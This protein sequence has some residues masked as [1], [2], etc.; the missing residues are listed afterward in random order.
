MASALERASEKASST[1]RD[2]L[3]A[4]AAAL[5]G[6]DPRL[7]VRRA[8]RL[9]GE[10]AKVGGTTLNLRNF[11]RVIVVGAGKA[12]ALMAAELERILRG[13]VDRGVVIVPEYQHPIPK[14]RRVR[15]VKST[16]P[17]PSKKGVRATKKI[18]AVLGGVGEEDLVVCLLSGGASSLMP[19]P[20]EGVS[21]DDIAQ[22][23]TLLQKAGAEIGEVNCVRKHLSQI[24]GGR[25]VEKTNGAVVLSLIM[26]DVVGDDLSAVASGPTVPDTTT[27]AEAVGVLRRLKVWDTVPR[28]IRRT[29]RAGVQGRV[30]E[31]P[32]PGSALF[33]KVEN[34]L[35]GSNTGACDQA[36]ALLEREGYHVASFLGSV[37]G[38]A[39]VVGKQLALLARSGRQG[40]P[41]GAVWGGETTVTVRG[42]GVGGRNQEVALAAAIA[43]KGSSGITVLSLGTDGI[44][45]PTDAA[46]AIADSTTS[47]RA[48]AR[49]LDP[50]YFLENNDSNSFFRAL[51]DLVVTG[52]TG[53]NVNDVMIALRGRD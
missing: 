14:L 2:A 46:G 44:D 37:T 28:S 8:L 6:A 12:S 30:R 4:A 51:G 22:T 32:K 11:R 1:R 33:K 41:W 16:H 9:R 26:S 48:R 34:I 3:L 25:L 20:V 7:M 31:T 24:A 18:L 19:L 21:V 42:E 47:E 53:T 5:R 43:L 10:M 52:P 45:G 39:R 23:T 29:L 13:R 50:L 38:E 49:G 27:F 36:R 15:I 40:G 17:L 35:V